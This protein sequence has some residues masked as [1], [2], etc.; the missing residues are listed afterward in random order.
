MTYNISMLYLHQLK[1]TGLGSVGMRTTKTGEE[2]V[3][4]PRHRSYRNADFRPLYSCG[5]AS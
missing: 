1:D 5:L 4:W 2:A 3:N